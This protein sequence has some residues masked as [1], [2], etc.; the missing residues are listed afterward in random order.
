MLLSHKT[1]QSFCHYND[2][3]MI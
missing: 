1:Q 2:S 3:T